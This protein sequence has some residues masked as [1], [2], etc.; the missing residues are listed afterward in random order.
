M[1]HGTIRFTGKPNLRFIII[2]GET[3]LSIKVICYLKRFLE[4]GFVTPTYN[5]NGAIIH[6]TPSTKR[7]AEAFNELVPRTRSNT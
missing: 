5:S 6:V 3:D 4:Q 7:I 1:L 2:D